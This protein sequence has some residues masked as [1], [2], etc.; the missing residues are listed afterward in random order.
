M[1]NKIRG[2]EYYMNMSK[3]K[4]R[5]LHEV[6]F[7]NYSPYDKEKGRKKDRTWHFA[8]LFVC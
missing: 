4:K 6:L 5:I 1:S 3:K 8:Q 2:I 7:I